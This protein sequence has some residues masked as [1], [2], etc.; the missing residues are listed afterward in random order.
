[1]P[2]AVKFLGDGPQVAAGPEGKAVS[3]G[4]LVEGLDQPLELLACQSRGFTGGFAG[5]KGHNTALAVG[6]QGCD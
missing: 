4:S 2:Y 5:Q 6:P 1:M 3:L